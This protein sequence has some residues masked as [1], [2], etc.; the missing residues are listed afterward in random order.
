MCVGCFF[1]LLVIPLFS[2]DSVARG[3][4]GVCVHMRTLDQDFYFQ[5]L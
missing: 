4:G 5:T 1:F 3:I 2:K